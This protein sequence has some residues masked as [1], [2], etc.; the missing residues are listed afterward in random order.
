M[1]ST[2]EVSTAL[3][4]TIQNFWN[5]AVSLDLCVPDISTKHGA[6]AFRTAS[7]SF[8]GQWSKSQLLIILRCLTTTGSDCNCSF[9]RSLWFCGRSLDA[10][11]KPA[12]GRY[13]CLPVVSFAS[14]QLEVSG[15]GWSL[16]QRS[17]TECGVSECDR[18]WPA[19]DFCAI[20]SVGF[21]RGL[22]LMNEVSPRDIFINNNNIFI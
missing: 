13:V 4:R 14:C 1:R 19:G 10:G 9:W 22:T 20:K 3:E 6:Y 15:S 2:P 12:R 16:V 18:P 21:V 11:S 8:C 7:H 5:I 17:P